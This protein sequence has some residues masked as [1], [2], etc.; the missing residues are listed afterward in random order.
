MK[1][2]ICSVFLTFLFIISYGQYGA[3]NGIQVRIVPIPKLADSLGNINDYTTPLSRKI[4]DVNKA[5]NQ[6]TLPLVE[7]WKKTELSIK[8]EVQKRGPHKMR[9]F[10]KIPSEKLEELERTFQEKF[11]KIQNN[12]TPAYIDSLCIRLDYINGKTLQ[13]SVVHTQD[14]RKDLSILANDFDKAD[15]M[16]HFL[17]QRKQLLEK[18]L[19]GSINDTATF[20][21]LGEQLG[22]YHET[23]VKLKQQFTHLLA[24]E[25][26]VNNILEQDVNY[27]SFMQEKVLLGDNYGIYGRIR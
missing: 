20:V 15:A 3:N 17:Q 16:Q 9:I 25:I 24:I 23:V 18:S 1:G 5:L 14:L 8:E 13:N 27:R 4:T 26:R 10:K 19:K 2:F 12:K 11:V 21:A 7:E 6:Q 22:R